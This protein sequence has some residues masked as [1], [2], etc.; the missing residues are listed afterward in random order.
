MSS[1]S[2][3]I[4]RKQNR[5][6]NT[7]RNLEALPKVTVTNP[8]GDGSMN[9]L[10]VR[11]PQEYVPDFGFQWCPIMEHYRVYIH[12]ATSTM[13]KDNAG[14][15]ICTIGSGLSAMGFGALYTFLH[16]HRANNK[17]AAYA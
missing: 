12:I 9:T 8:A 6:F 14:Y 5:I 1:N 3:A 4:H 11:H 17:K 15:C 13:N 2:S 16:K 7:L 10:F